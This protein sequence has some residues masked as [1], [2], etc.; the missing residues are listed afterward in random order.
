MKRKLVILGAPGAG[1]GACSSRISERLGIPQISTGE[2]LRKERTIDSDLGMKA[3]EYMDSGELVPDNIVI[4]LLEK[5]LAEPDCQNGFILDGFPRTLEQAQELDGV[6]PID[7]AIELVVPEEISVARLSTRRTCTK[8]GEVYNTKTLRPE[9]EGI[10]DKCGGELYQRSDADPEVIKERFKEHREKTQP[11]ID[12][13]REKGILFVALTED[14]NE[15]PE[16][17]VNQVLEKIG[18]KE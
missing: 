1:K 4:E 5:R 13:Y 9:T 17:K 10:C 14:I 18:F 6:M 2:L 7:L 16:V 11:V 12:Y 8:C 15:P 3:K